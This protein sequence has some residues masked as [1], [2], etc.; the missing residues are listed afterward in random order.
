MGV[1]EISG[2]VLRIVGICVGV[3]AVMLAVMAL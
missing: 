2:V 3:P 1:R